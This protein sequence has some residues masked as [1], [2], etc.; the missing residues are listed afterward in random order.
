MEHAG[1]RRLRHVQA[2]RS[3]VQVLAAAERH[4]HVQMLVTQAIEQA[5][6]DDRRGHDGPFLSI[7]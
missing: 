6:G 4:Q 1:C 3:A 5:A 2:L 7:P